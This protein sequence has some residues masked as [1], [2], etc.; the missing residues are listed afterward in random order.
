[1]DS[2]EKEMEEQRAR[3]K[4]SGKYSRNCIFWY[5]TIRLGFWTS[6][7]YAYHLGGC[8]IHEKMLCKRVDASDC[9]DHFLNENLKLTGGDK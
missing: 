1:M 6:I 8:R 3:A 9:P 7:E 2:Y 5:P 4:V